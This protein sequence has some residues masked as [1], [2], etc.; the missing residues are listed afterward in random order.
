VERIL[1]DDLPMDLRHL[2][3]TDLI[4]P[5]L[6]VGRP[7]DR[8]GA[9][10]ESMCKRG[11]ADE[12]F[13][14][15]MR[16]LC[17]GGSLEHLDHSSVNGKAS[18]S[19]ALPVLLTNE[20]TRSQV[21]DEVMTELR[22]TYLPGSRRVRSSNDHLFRPLPRRGRD[23]N[24][25]W[26][27]ADY[28]ENTPGV[29]AVVEPV[30]DWSQLLSGYCD[31]HDGYYR[32]WSLINAVEPSL[33]SDGFAAPVP[34]P[35]VHSQHPA[36]W[37]T[38]SSSNKNINVALVHPASSSATVVQPPG[39]SSSRDLDD[40]DIEYERLQFLLLR[41]EMFNFTRLR[42]LTTLSMADSL[43]DPIR[44][45]CERLEKNLVVIS[46][47]IV[48]SQKPARPKSTNGRS[49]GQPGMNRV[50]GGRAS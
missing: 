8:L 11:A 19:P 36:C 6:E 42:R 30:R 48:D 5:P 33:A 26:Q 4:P 31:S 1:R 29:A 32:D 23:Y 12:D 18:A 45:A 7:S 38:R 17:L 35:P 37:G 50:L 14:A 10:M 22:S 27:E 39:A 20:V 21:A 46:K 9:V 41:Q 44:D 25:T 40:L 24:D 47:S 15:A 49:N 3:G 34:P 43:I 16:T 28:L 13:A 2:V